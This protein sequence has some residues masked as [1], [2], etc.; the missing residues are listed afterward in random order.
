[1]LKTILNHI[2]PVTVDPFLLGLWEGEN[3]KPGDNSAVEFRAL[4]SLVG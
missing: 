1:M 2:K 4:Q 3:S